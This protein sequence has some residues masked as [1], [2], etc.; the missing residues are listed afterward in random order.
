MERRPDCLGRERGPLRDKGELERGL[1]DM[2]Q[3]LTALQCLLY[4][5]ASGPEGERLGALESGLA[6][7]DRLIEQVRAVQEMVASAK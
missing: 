5:G 6:L 1:H 3:P 7:C 4:L 2:S